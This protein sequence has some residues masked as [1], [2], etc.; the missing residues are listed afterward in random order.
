MQGIATVL[1]SSMHAYQPPPWGLRLP[2]GPLA[3]DPAGLRLRARLR[4]VLPWAVNRIMIGESKSIFRPSFCREGE[5]PEDE[6][7]SVAFV[8][9]VSREKL[10]ITTDVR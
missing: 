6:N 5:K 1:P 8:H 7:A 4:R 2:L 10:S 3:L 9:H